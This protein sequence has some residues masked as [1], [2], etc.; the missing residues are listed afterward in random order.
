MTKIPW[1]DAT[2]N[3]IR[4]AGGFHGCTKVSEGCLNCYA[5]DMNFRFDPQHRSYDY[6]FKDWDYYLLHDEINKIYKWRKPKRVFVCSMMDL[7]HEGVSDEMLDIVF[8]AIVDNKEHVFQILTKRPKRA[9]GYFKK[10]FENGLPK[11]IW[12][13][14][15][16]ENQKTADKRIPLLLEI[17]A[18]VRFLSV[19]PLL[20]EIV[21]DVCEE[22]PDWVIVGCETGNKKRE[23]QVEWVRGIVEQ[24]KKSLEDAPI[25]IKQLNIDGKVV[26]DIKKFPED[27]RIREYPI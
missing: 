22:V 8:E 1:T 26:K 25:F 14:V 11:N 13:G 10:R 23:C 16:V 18:A 4:V 17:P 19:E 20:E 5:S 7:F 2:I 27:L 6:K 3:P 21:I 15:S 12:F 9:K 24:S